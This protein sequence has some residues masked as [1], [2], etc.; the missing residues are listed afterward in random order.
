MLPPSVANLHYFVTSSSDSSEPLV[1]NLENVNLPARLLSLRFRNNVL[2]L[3]HVQ[4]TYVHASYVSLVH[5]PL[6]SEGS[7]IITHMPMFSQ[8]NDLKHV[9]SCPQRCQ[10]WWI[11]PFELHQSR[12]GWNTVQA[13]WTQAQGALTALN[14]ANRL[15]L[16]HYCVIRVGGQTPVFLY[17]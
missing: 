4:L 3:K 1:F 17:N 6:L 14:C 12:Y 7:L 15:T 10:N 8:C 5:W 2:T 16:Q 13:Y 9:F 11:P